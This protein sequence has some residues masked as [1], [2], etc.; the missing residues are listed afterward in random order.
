MLRPAPFDARLA[1][2]R[3]RRRAAAGA[4]L[5]LA[6]LAAHLGLL[7]TASRPSEPAA[8]PALPPRS[9]T[10]RLLPVAP[11]LPAAAP[12]VAA[13]LGAM[14]AR[15]SVAA[16]PVARR[17][18][19]PPATPP[20][21]RAPVAPPPTA[22]VTA[23]PPLAEASLPVY[24]TQL[25]ASARL[26][27]RLQRGAALGSGRLAWSLRDGAYERAL[28]GGLQGKAVLG[29]TSRGAIDA[30]GVAPL[31]MVDRRGVRAL[32]AVNFQR[33]AMRI[34]FSGPQG[35]YPLHRG[36]QD[37]L[38]WM[39]QLPAIVAAN[40]AL[41]TPG[42]HITLFVAGTRGDAEAWRF[43]VTGPQPIELGGGGA[44]MALRLMRE[45]QRPYVTRI[46]VWLDPARQ[47]LPV[48]VLFT[49]VPDGTPTELLLT[50][51][52]DGAS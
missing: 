12:V 34:T 15:P 16:H 9:V 25:P 48:R 49:T 11:T 10:L 23:A 37:R 13:A 26:S 39:I 5:L 45:A 50:D 17:A 19:M 35:D 28:E 33:D 36:A 22:A 2:R 43:D 40:A 6:V 21:E 46:E 52:A 27:F 29:A 7:R 51:I 4:A 47:H 3:R 18:P 8:A 31:R 42:G 41:A 32:R 14:P 1:G 20:S 30:D 24:P 44:V 38:S